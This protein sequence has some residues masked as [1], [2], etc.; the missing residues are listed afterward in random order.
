MG[1][2]SR[3]GAAHVN[4]FIVS[5]A[6]SQASLQKIKMKTNPNMGSTFQWETTCSMAGVGFS[7][8][9]FFFFFSAKWT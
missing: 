9:E 5:T 1:T 4:G 7:Q 2:N 8:R 6:Q 3:S